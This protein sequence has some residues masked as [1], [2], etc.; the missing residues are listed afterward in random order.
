MRRVD[1][2]RPLREAMERAGLS[3]PQLAAI[4]KEIDPDGRG[5]SQ[6]LIGFY[7]STGRSGREQAS[8]RAAGLMVAALES[9]GV[10]VKDGEIF[11]DSS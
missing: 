2:G 3:I 8:D 5:V 10:D 4:T 9:A 6:S 11:A 7:T 1:N